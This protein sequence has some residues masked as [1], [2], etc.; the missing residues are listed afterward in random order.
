MVVFVQFK[1][2]DFFFNATSVI[3]K[4]L[5]QS[6]PLQQQHQRLWNHRGCPGRVDQPRRPSQG[7]PRLL[8][9]LLAVRQRQHDPRHGKQ[10]DL[11]QQCQ[12]PVDERHL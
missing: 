9:D 3:Q 5:Q 8:R 11:E 7:Q 4:V 12:Q 6:D 10:H 1:S 2:G